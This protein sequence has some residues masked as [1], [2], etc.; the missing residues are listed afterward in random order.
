MGGSKIIGHCDG[1]LL[2]IAG[3]GEDWLSPQQPRRLTPGQ[4]SLTAVAVAADAGCILVRC[5][6]TLSCYHH[7]GWLGRMI[8]LGVVRHTTGSCDCDA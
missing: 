5:V 8:F 2:V 7:D 1:L 3:Q 6:I 4:L